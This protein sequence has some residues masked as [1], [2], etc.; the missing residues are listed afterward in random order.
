MREAEIR[1]IAKETGANYNLVARAY[2]EAITEEKGSITKKKKTRM[3]LITKV[4]R[5][6]QGA[7]T[8]QKTM[9]KALA[10]RIDYPAGIG[11]TVSGFDDEDDPVTTANYLGELVKANI[12]GLL[13]VK[14]KSG[15]EK[16]VFDITRENAEREQR[17]K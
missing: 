5:I 9:P 12:A 13:G 10:F 14:D 7:P 1:A 4:V 8:P 6:Y 3:E 17:R 2:D 16:L 11:I 15:V